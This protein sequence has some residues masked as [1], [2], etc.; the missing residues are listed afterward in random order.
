MGRPALLLVVF[1]W[2]LLLHSLP[3]KGD[4][5]GNLLDP[6]AV[7]GTYESCSGSNCWGGTTGGT[8]PSWDGS[9]AYWGYGAGLL[10][11]ELAIEQALKSVGVNIDGYNY[12]WRVKNKDANATQGCVL[13][14]FNWF[15]SGDGPDYM[16]VSVQFY[17]SSGTELWGKQYNLDGTYDWKNFSGQELFTTP[18]TGNN[19]ET[20]IVRAEG[21]DPGN[22]AG[23]YG[24]EFDASLSSVSLIYSNNPCWPDPLVDVNCDGY[25]EAYTQKILQEQQQ[26][27]LESQSVQEEIYEEPIVEQNTGI[28]DSQTNPTEQVTISNAAEP[29]DKSDG[30]RKEVDPIGIA[31]NAAADNAAFVLNNI[32]NGELGGTIN[33]LETNQTQG[34]LGMANAQTQGQGSSSSN[35]SN[36]EERLSQSQKL[37]QAAKERAAGLQKEIVES[38]DMDEQQAQQQEMLVMMNFVPGF[39]AYKIALAGGTYPDVA[40]YAPT[41][42][43]DSPNGKRNNFAQQLLHQQ[44][45]D[46]QYEER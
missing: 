12:V 36:S 6:S 35:Q 5:T 10:S 1:L 34:A 8:I 43:P 21:D 40:F 27:V 33:A 25:A 16:R 11:W 46:M 22:W 37:K 15:C 28:Q 7:T 38:E 17:D 44:M 32:V 14:A 3:S 19:I 45:V 4:T 29:E 18:F 13:S 20:I 31:L 41:T 30:T 2:L 23:H 42:V 24:P 26:A 39:D 9:T